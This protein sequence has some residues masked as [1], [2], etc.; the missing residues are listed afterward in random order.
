MISAL[1]VWFMGGWWFVAAFGAHVALSALLATRERRATI[2]RA[3]PLDP[4]ELDAYELAMLDS[5]GE[6]AAVRLGVVALLDRGVL[7]PGRKWGP[8][9]EFGA[10][11]FSLI[12]A[13]EIGGDAHPLEREIV[14]AVPPVPPLTA[15]K[16]LQKLAR[17]DTVARMRT[18]LEDAGLVYR[19]QRVLLSSSVQVSLYLLPWI[20]F[21]GW[22]FTAADGLILGLG[23][24]LVNLLALVLLSS[25]VLA[26]PS[27]RGTTPLGAAV[28]GGAPDGDRPDRPAGDPA[29]VLIHAYDTRFVGL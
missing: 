24:F 26:V 8:R 4:A 19:E 12:V 9:K 21:F 25:L 23:E 16:L 7:K 28:L 10:P 14:A 15:E 22:T 1:R 13:R 11:L 20:A 6:L 29:Q 18:K 27:T 17:C 2:Q 5:D 3:R